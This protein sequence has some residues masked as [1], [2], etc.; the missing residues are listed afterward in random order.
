[1]ISFLFNQLLTV[2][3]ISS[4]TSSILW[5]H[6]NIFQIQINLAIN[7]LFKIKVIKLFVSYIAL[8]LLP[9]SRPIHGV[10]AAQEREDCDYQEGTRAASHWCDLLVQSSISSEGNDQP[11]KQTKREKQKPLQFPRVYLTLS[12]S[13]SWLSVLALLLLDLKQAAAWNDIYMET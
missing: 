9:A 11:R 4:F 2:P 3:S 6:Q 8:V 13:A 5:P 1:M 12:T 10:C 7:K